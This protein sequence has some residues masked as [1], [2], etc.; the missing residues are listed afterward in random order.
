MKTS[1]ASTSLPPISS[2]IHLTS[3]NV[4]KMSMVRWRQA[5]IHQERRDRNDTITILA[6]ELN[7]SQTILSKLD[8]LKSNLSQF[9]GIKKEIDLAEKKF[10]QEMIALRSAERD[11]RWGPIEP[12]EILFG[13]PEVAKL[14]GDVKPSESN[15]VEK[16]DKII[17][18]V[19]ARIPVA[20]KEADRLKEEASSKLTSENMYKEGFSKTVSYF[21]VIRFSFNCYRLFPKRLLPL[22]NLHQLPRLRPQRRL[23]RS[24]SLRKHPLNQI[25]R[26]VVK[27]KSSKTPW[28]C[29]SR[30]FEDSQLRFRTSRLT[31]TL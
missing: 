24:T 15:G 16:I 6:S 20:A 25:P 12:I 1:N 29:D 26:L 23:K 14:L 17:E 27:T 4:D 2:S 10:I 30:L 21:C 28:Y 19:K 18:K 31:L 13:R 9:V 5:K 7:L 3:P 8:A 11:S 22:R